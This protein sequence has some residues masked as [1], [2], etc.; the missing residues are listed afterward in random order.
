MEPFN[1]KKLLTQIISVAKKDAEA[2]HKGMENAKASAVDAQVAMQATYDTTRQ[3]QSWLYDALCQK[4]NSL[5]EF[6]AKLNSAVND[7]DSLIGTVYCVEQD[8]IEKLFVMVPEGYALNLTKEVEAPI[9]EFELECVSTNSPLGQCLMETSEEYSPFE[10]TTPDG[11]HIE[12][13]VN[14]IFR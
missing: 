12:G 8:H 5:M 14:D 13:W 10:F 3:E 6:I 11:R 2:I 4:Y 9:P 1:K 7:K